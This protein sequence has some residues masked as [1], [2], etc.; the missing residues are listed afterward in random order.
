MLDDPKRLPET[1]GFATAGW[2]AAPA[3][4]RVIDRIAP[5]LNVK[6]AAPTLAET[7][8][9]AADVKPSDDETT[10]GDLAQ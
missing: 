3:A 7:A 2:N 10:D 1:F 6:R 9:S 4:G 5:F 8:K